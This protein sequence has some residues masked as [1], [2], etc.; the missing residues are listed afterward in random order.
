M[1]N[2]KQSVK[3][4]QLVSAINIDKMKKCDLKIDENFQTQDEYVPWL[5]TQNIYF[6]FNHLCSHPL[7]VIDYPFCQN[8]PGLIQPAPQGF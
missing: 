6:A 4:N 8:A 3:S 2:C 5:D 7:A 1:K